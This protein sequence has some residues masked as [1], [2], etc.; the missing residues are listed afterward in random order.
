MINDNKMQREGSSY[1]WNKQAS[2]FIT[3]ST[4]SHNHQFISEV[5]HIYSLRYNNVT[6]T[7]WTSLINWWLWLWTSS[8]CRNC[9]KATNTLLRWPHFSMI[10]KCNRWPAIST[11]PTPTIYIREYGPWQRSRFPGPVFQTRHCEVIH[12]FEWRKCECYFLAPSCRDK[13][14][15]QGEKQSCNVIQYFFFPH[16]L[17]IQSRDLRSREPWTALASKQYPRANA[18]SAAG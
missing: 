12:G 16:E 6:F 9:E 10:C 17:F 4:L 7:C 15:V 11:N 13:R 8:L 1:Y 2:L 5:Q 18:V 14:C 3:V